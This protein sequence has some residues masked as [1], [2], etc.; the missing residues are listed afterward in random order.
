MA[1]IKG[2]ATLS[3]FKRKGDVSC[4]VM[5][6][7]SNGKVDTESIAEATKKDTR[8]SKEYAIAAVNT[9]TSEMITALC[10][11]KRIE[12]PY[13]S[14]YLKCNGRF[15]S[16][17]DQFDPKRHQLGIVFVPK[18]AMKK[19][20]A[21]LTVENLTEHVKVVLSLVRTEGLEEKNVIKLGE[22]VYNEGEGLTLVEGREDEYAALLDKDTRE[23]VAKAEV[24]SSSVGT[25]TA[26][27][28][29]GSVPAGEYLYVVSSRNGGDEALTPFVAE[30]LVKVIA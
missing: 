1:K 22:I 29:K 28:A 10:D 21:N 12:T 3:Q 19:M 20:L 15:E 24:L 17:T 5:R 26:R 9:L 30:K 4:Y 11:G 25:L 8:L 2:T 23:F 16:P 6:L 18:A 27:F 13:F 7:T 14:M